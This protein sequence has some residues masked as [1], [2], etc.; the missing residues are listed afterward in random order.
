M[1]G[2]FVFVMVI[3]FRRVFGICFNLFHDCFS[4]LLSDSN[5]IISV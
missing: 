1:D 5:I 2:I 4:Q 3:F